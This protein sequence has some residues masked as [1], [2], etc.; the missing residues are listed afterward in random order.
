MDHNRFSSIPDAL[1]HRE[2]TS[3][4]ETAQKD[5]EVLLD[6]ENPLIADLQTWAE[7]TQ[8]LLQRI[9]QQGDR[10]GASHSPQQAMALGSFRT[11]LI[12]GLQALKA[13]QS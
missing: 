4:M 12:L 7:G 9:S 5:V 13:S 11:H 2:L 3:L 8:L 10:I 6:E 1:S